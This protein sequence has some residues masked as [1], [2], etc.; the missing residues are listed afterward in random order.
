M[1]KDRN[2]EDGRNLD[3]ASVPGGVLGTRSLVSS[4]A[5]LVRGLIGRR[6]IRTGPRP[7]TLARFVRHHRTRKQPT[8]YEVGPVLVRH[9]NTGRSPRLTEGRKESRRN[10]AQLATLWAYQFV[11][12]TSP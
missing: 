10:F 5:G 11:L 1:R 4:T 3:D 2:K 12:N 8:E 9:H 7:Q 6:A